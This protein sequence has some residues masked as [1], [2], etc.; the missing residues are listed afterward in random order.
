MIM[1]QQHPTTA[2][3]HFPD[4]RGEGRMRLDGK[5]RVRATAVQLIRCAEVPEKKQE[6]PQRSD[7]SLR[8]ANGRRIK[9]TP[10]R[11]ALVKPRWFGEVTTAVAM[12]GYVE[13]VRSQLMTGGYS[14]TGS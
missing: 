11:T 13:I 6:P 8:R 1:N 12:P 10:G 2:K 3:Q 14:S 7:L 9:E 4:P 5:H